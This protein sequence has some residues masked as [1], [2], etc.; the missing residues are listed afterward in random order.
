MRGLLFLML[1]LA[2]PSFADEPSFQVIAYHDVRDDVTGDYDPDQYAVST[3]NLITQFTWLREQGFQP[4]SV[5]DI[6]A[7]KNGGPPLPER[8][9]LLTFDDGLQSFY[10]KVYPL[11]KLFRYPAVVSVV[12]AWIESDVQVSYGN[13]LFTGSNFLTWDQLIEM[14]ASGLVEVGS[15]SH[16]LHRGV[17]GTPQGNQMPAAVTRIYDGDSYE[18]DLQYQQRIATD[19][20][21][22]VDR[23]RQRTGRAPRVITWP[24]GA[25]NDETAAIAATLG[26]N[27]SL[28]L[29]HESSVRNGSMHIGR[30][31]TVSN[32]SLGDF[33]AALMLDP[34]PEVVRVAQV[35][36]D[37]VY[38]PDPRQQERNLDRLIDRMKALE[39]SHVF[40]QAYADPDAD[41]GA[42]AL[43]F[44]NRHL[45]VRADLFARVAWQ[46][47]TRT[48]VRVYAWLP[49]LSFVGDSFEAG[50][51]VQEY[52][53]GL[54]APDPNSEPR[55][56]PFNAQATARIA[57]IYEDLAKHARFDGLLF[58]D[59]G[60]LNEFEDF[61]ESAMAVY[62][63]TFGAN[64]TPEQLQG[65]PAMG[66]RWARLKSQT[67]LEF[68]ITLSDVV[69]RYQ[70]DLKTARNIFANALLDEQGIH[71]LAQDFDQ[72]LETY[73]YVALMA[74]P[75]L[76]GA[77]NE[78]RFFEQLVA[79]VHS[80]D[81]AAERTI[82]ELQTVDWRQS[83]PIDGRRL[84]QTMRWLQSLGVRHLGYYPDDFIGGHPSLEDLRLGI[85]LANSY[86]EV[87]P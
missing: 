31:M 80:R 2:M 82:F 23:I 12:T 78:R 69:R 60:R 38:D 5:D 4:V 57:E 55:L 6:I 43:Y 45:P 56:S 14:Q 18:T 66:E 25:F 71:Y 48:Y 81:G 73:D 44:P 1:L 72:Y 15:H 58:H 84:R 49:M 68:G 59:D 19:L 67:L 9:V 52:R 36:L 64:V 61:S 79:A 74:M 32:P 87:L 33:S 47:K 76:E 37:Y 35:D 41:G 77:E 24:Y 50:W 21:L 62:R 26:M 75:W 86:G 29:S 7:A 11:L 53:D 34:Y 10:T 22:S 46:L 63:D 54:V 42:D 83:A 40:L 30:Y 3:S 28:T 13:E 70:S 16:D 51:R 39:I 8:A 17:T 85:S 27:I 20:S 65:D